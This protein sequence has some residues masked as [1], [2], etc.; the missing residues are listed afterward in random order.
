MLRRYVSEE[1][2]SKAGWF[3]T[4]PITQQLKEPLS[5][6]QLLWP[7]PWE[8]LAALDHIPQ[9]MWKPFGCSEAGNREQM[10]E[11][12]VEAAALGQ[13]VSASQD[14]PRPH[15][16]IQMVIKACVFREAAACIFG[17]A[18]REGQ[19]LSTSPKAT[20]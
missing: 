11:V 6:I 7:Q 3:V 8:A 14:S 9:Q 1:P 12:D 4:E 19:Y 5:G 18:W 16:A 2:G 13:N 20:A 17:G 10:T 15:M